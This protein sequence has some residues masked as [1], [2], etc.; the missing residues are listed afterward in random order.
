[1]QLRILLR[2]AECHSSVLVLF[3]RFIVIRGLTDFCW[4]LSSV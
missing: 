1:L 4:A 3:V 2:G